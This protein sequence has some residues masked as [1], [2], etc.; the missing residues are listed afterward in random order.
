V[1]GGKSVGSINQF[2]GFK[3]NHVFGPGFI[4]PSCAH[5]IKQC[6]VHSVLPVY[7]FADDTPSLSAVNSL[8][9]RKYVGLDIA[10]FSDTALNE[11][12]CLIRVNAE[13]VAK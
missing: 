8:F 13:V 1:K 10:V 4:S 12:P 7:Y 11:A 2:S 3:I 5:H 6:S 9:S